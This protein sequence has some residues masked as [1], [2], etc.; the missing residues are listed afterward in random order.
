MSKYFEKETRY[1]VAKMK[2]VKECLTVAEKQELGRLIEKCGQNYSKRNSIPLMCVVVESDWPEYDKVWS[3][4]EDRCI[5]EGSG[6]IEKQR[7]KG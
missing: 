2:D 1:V 6:F 7:D 4:I 3:M 5:F